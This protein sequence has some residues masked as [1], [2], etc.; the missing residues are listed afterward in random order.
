MEMKYIP[1]HG[2]ENGTLKDLDTRVTSLESKTSQYSSNVVFYN[3]TTTTT[4]NITGPNTNKIYNITSFFFASGNYNTN[5]GLI[6]TNGILTYDSINQRLIPNANTVGKNIQLTIS[7]IHDNPSLTAGDAMSFIIGLNSVLN[8][9]LS[10]Y[11]NGP[12]FTNT[13]LQASLTVTPNLYYNERVLLDF[14]I[15]KSATDESRVNGFKICIANRNNSTYDFN[16]MKLK[17]LGTVG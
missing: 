11:T 14:F 12:I 5:E 15:P 1:F 16:N 4:Y 7:L 6:G 13:T 3:P 9:N 2:V 8:T 17:I 10:P